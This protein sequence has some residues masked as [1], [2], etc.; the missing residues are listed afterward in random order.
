MKLNRRNLPLNAMRA[1]E[2][3]ARHCHMRRAAEELGVTH[4]A[5]SRQVKQLEELLGVSL[6]DRSHNRLS[7]THAGQRLQQSVQQALD[8][9]TTGALYLDPDSMNGD[10]TLAAT[11][12]AASAWLL[13]I[14]GRFAQQYPEINIQLRSIPPR[15][16]HIDSQVDVAVCY[17][18]PESSTRNITALFR[19]RYVPVCN[20]KLLT[21]NRQIRQPLELLDYP[22][23]C[24]RHNNWP[25]WFQAA[26]FAELPPYKQLLLEESFLVLDAVKAGYGIALAD[27]V[28]VHRELNNGQLIALFEESLSAAEEYYLVTQQQTPSLRSQ[29]F[30]DFLRQAIEP[31]VAM[32]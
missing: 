19:E 6:F 21:G 30:I 31:I 27:R 2:M 32:E 10:L 28:E 16:K 17:G 22:L 29:L 26:G 25:R 24:D 18:A 9:M 20:P 15:I 13:D 4:G 23:L 12:S 5:L 3:A 14:I 7:L 11:P 1:F 8:L